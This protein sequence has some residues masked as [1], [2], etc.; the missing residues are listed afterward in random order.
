MVVASSHIRRLTNEQDW[1]GSHT[2]MRSSEYF[3]V[4]HADP[5][6]QARGSPLLGGELEPRSSL[7]HSTSPQS[8]PDL[9]KQAL[10]ASTF[11][12]I[13]LQ[14]A[15]AEPCSCCLFSNVNRFCVTTLVQ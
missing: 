14:I 13:M 11:R 9:R 7:A 8:G 10:H 2:P 5:G 6:V 15:L 1:K 12:Q 3:G 4:V